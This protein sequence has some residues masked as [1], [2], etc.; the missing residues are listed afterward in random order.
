MAHNPSQAALWTQRVVAFVMFL[1]GLT[2]TA[3]GAVLAASGGSFYY[4]LTGLALIASGVLIWR[5]DAR[6]VWLYGAMLVWTVAC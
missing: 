4:V 1:V 3:G 6:G 5:G 2:L